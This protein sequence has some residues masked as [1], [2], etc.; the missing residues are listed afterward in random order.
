MNWNA[1]IEWLKLKPQYM[2]P[3]SLTTGVITLG[4][5]TLLHALH[6]EGIAKTY[7]AWFGGAFLL[8]TALL[9]SHG[10]FLGVGTAT[11]HCRAKKAQKLRIDRLHKLTDAEKAVLRGYFDEGTPTQHLRMSDG[12]AGHLE[13]F[14]ILFRSSDVSV[15][16]DLFPYNLHPWAREYLS[17]HPELLQ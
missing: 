10:A 11:R 3:I 1:S 12:I 2:L 6:L 8:S 13:G 5:P 9:V 17:L 7:P 14:R 15:H 16:Q 4:P